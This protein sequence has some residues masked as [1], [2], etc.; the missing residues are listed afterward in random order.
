MGEIAKLGFSFPPESRWLDADAVRAASDAA[1]TIPNTAIP[2]E[3]TQFIDPMV[4]E[5]LTTPRRARLL[6]DEVKKGDWTTSSVK[7][8]VDEMV[9][10]SVPYSDSAN[11]GAADVNSN[12]LTREQYIYETTINYGQLESAIAAAAK[13]DLVASKQKAAASV[14]DDDENRFY[15]YGVVGKDIYGFL[16]DPNLP[17]S[18]AVTA[19]ATSGK[20]GWA[21]KTPEEIY[22][23]ILACF[24]GLVTS[25]G[26]YVAASDE[27]RLALSPGLA[28]MLGNATQ[29]NVSVND[30]LSKYFSNL[31]IITIP[32]LRSSAG[33]ERAV[34]YVP[35][36]KGLP[37]GELV[38][39]QKLM[40]HALIQKPSSWEQK[41][42]ASTF[43]CLIYYPVAFASITGM[44]SAS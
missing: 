18:V 41:Y 40:A 21:L 29:Y 37:T 3:F 20:I 17:A 12:W 5:I 7:F 2:A 27:L 23:D 24:K 11:G 35:K 39:G 34:M 36:L 6:L 28:V 42:S 31:K 1:V 13:L 44:E 14:L 9:G 19:G 43:G 8:R 30:M 25:T 38:F 16:N 4:V 26:G 32:E 10:R 22:A 33:A 15:L